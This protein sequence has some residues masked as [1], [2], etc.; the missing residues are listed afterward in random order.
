MNDD[1]GAVGG[2][3]TGNAT[4][5]VDFEEG[6]SPKPFSFAKVS[7]TL[8]FLF[9]CYC[10]KYLLLCLLF[11]MLQCTSEIEKAQPQYWPTL[12]KKQGNNATV[13]PAP[14][15]SGGGGKKKPNKMDKHFPDLLDTIEVED[16]QNNNNNIQMVTNIPKG[17]SAAVPLT[18]GGASKRAPK[19]KQQMLL[20]S[21]EMNFNRN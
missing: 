8:G 10:Q 1:E 14:E 15:S 5:N 3:A 17:N 19:K 4:M 6:N 12:N 7:D 20:F 18:G 11:Q 16:E 21:T 13:W 2:M 9:I